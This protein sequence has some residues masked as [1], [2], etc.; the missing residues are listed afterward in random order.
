MPKLAVVTQPAVGL[1]WMAVWMAQT[2]EVV[3]IAMCGCG[4]RLSR[5]SRQEA[6]DA[7]PRSQSGSKT[8]KQNFPAKL[9][10]SAGRR[11]P[12]RSGTAGDA[13]FLTAP[14]YLLVL[15]AS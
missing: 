14:E 8:G 5:P 13:L 15:Q 4:V 11:D 7:P 1:E 9:P 10:S 12:F 6:D 3:S 2:S